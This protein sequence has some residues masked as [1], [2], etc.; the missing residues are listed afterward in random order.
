MQKTRFWA[1]VMMVSLMVAFSWACSSAA[2]APRVDKETVKGWLGNP[3][4]VIVDVRA[5]SDWQDSKTK[6]KGAV[7]QAPKGVQTWVPVSPKTR[8]SSSTAPERM[9]APAPVWRRIC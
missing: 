8:K 9:K 6:I 2:G 5:G 3:Q 1:M 4:V 7:R